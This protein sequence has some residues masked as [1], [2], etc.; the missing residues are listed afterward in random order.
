MWKH[1]WLIFSAV[2]MAGVAVAAPPPAPTA[3]SKNLVTGSLVSKAVGSL[4]QVNIVNG[5][6][7]GPQLQFGTIGMAFTADDQSVTTCFQSVAV[8]A[9]EIQSLCYSLDSSDSAAELTL[10]VW[11]I[12]C[13]YDPPGLNSA[14]QDD[15]KRNTVYG[16]TGQVGSAAVVTG[17]AAACVD[18]HANALFGAALTGSTATTGLMMRHTIDASATAT[19]QVVFKAKRIQ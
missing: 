18:F 3:N 16:V 19:A 11:Q 1:G 8:Q 4:P 10:E 9:I 17:S 15:A 5:A 2:V 12:D 6:P 7:S 14:N 13:Q